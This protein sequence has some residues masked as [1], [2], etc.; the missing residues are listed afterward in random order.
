MKTTFVI[1]TDL[2]AGV[3]ELEARRRGRDFSTTL[4]EIVG[5]LECKLSDAV[6]WRD[7]VVSVGTTVVDVTTHRNG[8]A[9]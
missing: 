8:I 1:T 7:G 9:Q 6:R 4:Q 3:I 5:D 2:D